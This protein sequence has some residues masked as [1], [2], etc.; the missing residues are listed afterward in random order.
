V[1]EPAGH[2]W[3]PLV[4]QPVFGTGTIAVPQHDEAPPRTAVGTLRRARVTLRPPL[5]RR[6][7]PLP[8]PTAPAVWVHERVWALGGQREEQNMSKPLRSLT[9]R[10]DDS[11]S[12][13][14]C[15]QELT[16]LTAPE[17]HLQRFAWMSWPPRVMSTHGWSPVLC[18]TPWRGRC[19]G[20]G[21][22][23]LPRRWSSPSATVRP[24][25]ARFNGAMPVMRGW[26]ITDIA[27]P[28]C[29]P[30][31]VQVV[32]ALRGWLAD[33]RRQEDPAAGVP[34]PGKEGIDSVPPKYFPDH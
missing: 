26:P 9:I 16:A 1:A 6:A 29:P 7:E 34:K 12:C 19:C 24:A 23:S 27:I 30:E 17:H 32:A 8:A 18:P 20:C 13:N 28:G 2:W 5:H 10:H 3:A 15:E 11:G 21:K 25:V 33:R 4:V 14:G 31:P 22:P